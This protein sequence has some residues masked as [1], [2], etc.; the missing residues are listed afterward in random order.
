MRVVHTWE[1][2]PLLLD[3]Q[4]VQECRHSVLEWGY[5]GMFRW[6]FTG[7]GIR[8][9]DEVDDYIFDVFLEFSEMMG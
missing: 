2:S 9:F 5:N 6:V 4:L 7:R 1:V 8:V 3:G